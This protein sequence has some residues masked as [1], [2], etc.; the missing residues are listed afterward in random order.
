[1]VYALKQEGRTFCSLGG[2]VVLVAPQRTE[3]QG[4]RLNSTFCGST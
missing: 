1:M 4:Q 3:T 2:H